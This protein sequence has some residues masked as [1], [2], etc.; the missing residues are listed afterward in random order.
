MKVLLT[1][2]DGVDAA[3]LN[4]LRQGLVE[5]DVEV[6]AVA[7]ES[8]RSGAARACTSRVPVRVAPVEGG[9]SA[10]VYV[11]DG[12]PVDCVRAG[13]LT[14]IAP[15][16]AVVVSGMN[17]GA[18]LGD[19]SM[20]SATVGAAVE[21]ALLGRPGVCFSQQP[22]DGRFRFRDAGP[23]TF[24]EGAPIAVAVTRALALDPPPGRAALNVNFPARLAS[25]ELIVT[26]LGHRS[27]ELGVL[28][29]VE[30]DL[31]G[32]TYFL[33][34]TGD[35]PDPAHEGGEGTDFH[36]LAAGRVSATAIPLSWDD[37]DHAEAIRRWLDR[38][39]AR[40]NAAML[41]RSMDVTST[42]R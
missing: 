34:G 11:C 27:F 3:G 24:E 35:D 39:V 21:A 16:A 12:T 30:E 8:N 14:R 2:D 22:D 20:Y 19:D 29:P 15:D 38:F 26:R 18:N 17:H 7:P 9:D 13:L 10:R 4:R 42:E 5:A 28:T 23:H 1:N 31:S 6:V 33:Y 25:R 32:A 37:R 41:S 40:L 36:A